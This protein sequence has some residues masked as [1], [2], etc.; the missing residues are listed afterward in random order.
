MHLKEHQC[1][2]NRILVEE[3]K[4]DRGSIKDNQLGEQ[5][6]EVTNNYLHRAEEVVQHSSK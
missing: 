4:Q 6:Q 5:F 1:L 2:D 3:E